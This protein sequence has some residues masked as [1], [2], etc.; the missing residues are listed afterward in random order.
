M[1]FGGCRY[2]P[3]PDAKTYE[4]LRAEWIG[5][6]ISNRSI[7]SLNTPFRWVSH[8]G[9]ARRHVVRNC[10]ASGLLCQE[11]SCA[12]LA[13]SFAFSS[14]VSRS[15]VS[16]LNRRLKNIGSVDR[17]ESGPQNSRTGGCLMLD[18]ADAVCIGLLELAPQLAPDGVVSDDISRHDRAQNPL[19]FRT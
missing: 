13:T 12:A 5:A 6:H 4:C 19:I 7:L 8:G 1:R 17:R 14:A 15:S 18:D 16:G 10:R 2:P 3:S 9:K 11:R